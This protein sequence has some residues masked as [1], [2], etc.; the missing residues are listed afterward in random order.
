MVVRFCGLASVRCLTKFLLWKMGVSDL[1]R[2][3]SCPGEPLLL[4]ALV[5]GPCLLGSY[6]GVWRWPLIVVSVLA[7]V[8]LLL[9]VSPGRKA[10]LRDCILGGSIL[11]LVIQGVW[12]YFN[13]WGSYQSNPEVPHELGLVKILPDQPFPALPGAADRAGAMDK[14]SYIVPCLALI[15]AV[16]AVVIRHPD[17]PRKIAKAVFWTGVAVS[18]LGL[19]QRWT[20]AGSILWVESLKESNRG[21][22]FGTYRSPGIA[23]CYLNIA[24]A[25]GLSVLLSPRG[26]NRAPLRQNLRLL[27]GI[28]HTVGVGTLLVAATSA[29]S[30]AGMVFG[31][32]TLV[33]WAALN[34]HSIWR[35]FGRSAELFPGNR[36]MERNITT[37]VLVVSAAVA[38]LSFAGTVSGR[39][40]QAHSRGY[41]TLAGRGATNAVQLEMIR[42]GEWGVWG[43]GPGAFRAL[44]PVF[45]RNRD[46]RGVYVYGHNDYLET[47]VEWGWGGTLL[48]GVIVGGGVFLVFREVVFRKDAHRKSHVIY[49]RGWLVAMP[50]MLAHATV[51]FP[52]QIESIAVTFSVMLGMAWA[53]ADLGTGREVLGT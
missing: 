6:Y 42:D 34:R 29:G 18:A 50:V 31:F 43:F 14:L 46:I 19:V 10:S 23:T 47:A 32:L 16:R 13:A 33:L 39:W 26:R 4:L 41:A 5:L 40:E 48:L 38:V 52:F 45:A 24:L 28:L 7:S 30:K 36:R 8:S 49:M 3:V 44:F 22:F 27:S 15:W 21:L 53:S 11:V 20:G 25:S 51:D 1:R 37:L 17:L 2:Y 9:Q 35:A 12:M